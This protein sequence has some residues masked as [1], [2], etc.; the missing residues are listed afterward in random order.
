MPFILGFLF[1]G[2]VAF[3]GS[4]IPKAVATLFAIKATDRIVDFAKKLALIAAIMLL[5]GLEIKAIN[6][7]IALLKVTVPDEYTKLGAMFYPSNLPTCASII[8]AA[9][10]L[11]IFLVWKIRVMEYFV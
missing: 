2:L 11:R 7:A 5:I 6:E 8:T 4:M 1:R 9:S 10:L 3:F